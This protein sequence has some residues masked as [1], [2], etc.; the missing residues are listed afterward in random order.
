MTAPNHC[1]YSAHDFT[2]TAIETS[3]GRIIHVSGSGRCP[4]TS[5]ELRLVPANDGVVPHPELIRLE[6]RE[7]PPH[8]AT[9]QRTT[10]A[11]DAII[12]DLHAVQ[13]EIRFGW[14]DGFVI[15]VRTPAGPRAS[16]RGV[17]G[18]SGTRGDGA[19][20]NAASHRFAASVT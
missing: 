20:S 17:R 6:L 10:T 8:G 9:P 15:P 13:V 3:D 19:G 18:V 2:A 7:L 12:E 14:R 5:W 11:V 16:R 4:T 1:E